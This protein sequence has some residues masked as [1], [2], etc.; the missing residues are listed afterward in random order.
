MRGETEDAHGSKK[1]CKG[2]LSVSHIQ[3]LCCDAKNSINDRST[4]RLGPTSQHLF[5][6][7]YASSCRLSEVLK[8]Q[9]L[10]TAAAPLHRAAAGSREVV[11]SRSAFAVLSP[12]QQV[13]SPF[14]QEVWN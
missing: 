7:V 13:F 8:L 1:C 14:M 5:Q 12:S 6:G 4:A 11:L 2:S 9:L 3:I 10:D